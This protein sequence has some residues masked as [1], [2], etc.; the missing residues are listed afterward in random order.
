MRRRAAQGGRAAAQDERCS[1]SL[2]LFHGC[3]ALECTKLSVAD[4]PSPYL[5][6]PPLFFRPAGLDDLDAIHTLEVGQ[7]SVGVACAPQ[8]R[9]IL[10]MA[11]HMSHACCCP[12]AQAAGFPPDEAASRERLEY[13]LTHGGG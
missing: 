8:Q 12:L 9:A 5:Q 11:A 2:I 4:M 6:A 13:R 10:P 7:S 1:R 3:N